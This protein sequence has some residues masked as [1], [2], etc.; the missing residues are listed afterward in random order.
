MGARLSLLAPSAPTVALSSYI[1]VLGDWRYVDVVNNSRF[2]K[3]IR[4]IHVKSGQLVVIKVFIK[5]SLATNYNLQLTQVTELIAKEATLLSGAHNVLPWHKIIETDRAGYLIRQYMKT[6]LYDRLSIR[7]FLEPI[8]KLFI[9]FQL[10][11]AVLYLHDTLHVHH[12]DIKLENIL[13]SSS[14]WVTLSDFSGC[15]KPTFIPEDNPNQFSFYFDTNGRRVCYLAPERFFASSDKTITT[16][17]DEG[18]HSGSDRLTNEMDLFSLGCVIAELYN[19]GEPTFTLS[20]M[21]QYLK[22]AHRPDLS[23]LADPLVRA[24][25][26]G[27]ISRDPNGRKSAL[28]VLEDYR[29]TGFPEYFYDFLYDFMARIN[30]IDEKTYKGDAHVTVSDLKITEIYDMFATIASALGFLYSDDPHE[31]HPSNQMVPLCLSIPGVPTNYCIKPAHILDVSDHG[32]LVVLKL[33]FL[34]MRSLKQPESKLK[35][36]EL[37]VALSERVSDEC[38]LDCSV[39]YLCSFLDEFIE[40]VGSAMWQKV[41]E[42]VPKS[43]ADNYSVKVVCKTLVSITTILQ[44]CS[45]IPPIDLHMFP[46]YL[47]P[48][49][50]TLLASSNARP[51]HSLVRITIASCLPILASLSRKFWMMAKNFKSSGKKSQYFSDAH[52]NKL[53]VPKAQLDNDFEA[54]TVLLL[55]DFEA[56]VKVAFVRNIL[57]ICQFFGAQKANDIVLPHLI[58]FLNDPSD[59]LRSAFLGSVLEVGPFL[60]VITF[61]Q[62][63]L[64]LLVQTLGDCE[65]LVVVKVLEIF[66]LFV[67]SRFVNPLA[68]FN[69]LSIYREMLTSSVVLLL[70]PN[71]WIRQLVL[72]LVLAISDNLLHADRYT[73]LYPLIK[74]YLAFDVAELSWDSLY[75]C[76]VKPLTRQVFDLIISWSL[77]ATPKLLFWQQRTFSQLATGSGPRELLAFAKPLARSVYVPKSGREDNMRHSLPL[78]AEDKQWLLKLRAVGLEERDSWKVLAVREYVYHVSRFNY[79]SAKRREYDYGPV[80]ITPHNVFFEVCYKSELVADSNRTESRSA[81]F[82]MDVS[83]E[84]QRRD[85]GSLVL[86]NFKTVQASLETVRANVYGEIEVGDTRVG[87][88]HHLHSTKETLSSHHVFT[89]NRQKVVTANVKHSYTGTNPYVLQYLAGVRIAPAMESFEEFGSSVKAH[90]PGDD[91]G[92]NDRNGNDTRS[93]SGRT[94]GKPDGGF[95]L[96]GRLLSQINPSHGPDAV[97]CLELSPRGDFFVAGSDSGWLRVWDTAKLEKEVSVRSPSLVARV[98]ASVTS[99]R[100]LPGRSVV[101]AAT[102]DGRILLFRIDAVRHKKSVRYNGITQIRCYELD[103]SEDGYATHLECAN[104]GSVLVAA[105]T[106]GNFV[107]LDVI[108]MEC[109]YRLSA[110]LE[111]GAVNA[112]FMDPHATWLVCGSSMGILTLWDLRFRVV[113][114][115]WRLDMDFDIDDSSQIGSRFAIKRLL[116]LT[117]YGDGSDVHFAMVAGDREPDFSVWTMPKMECCQIYSSHLAYPQ[118]K[119][120]QLLPMDRQ[121]KDLRMEQLT[122]DV[123]EL[124]TGSEPRSMTVLHYSCLSGHH[125]VTSTPQGCITV[126]DVDTPSESRALGTTAVFKTT[127]VSS[128]MVLVNESRGAGDDPGYHEDIVTAAAITKDGLLITADRMGRINAFR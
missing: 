99:L 107:V 7:P 43:N 85:S 48:K 21:F 102:A 118:L 30:Q 73:F 82:A 91:R 19:D 25:V 88:H 122:Q 62:Y 13:V 64:P 22:T 103:S 127:K 54:L 115:T 117:G 65:Q 18:E 114:R 38:K 69:A 95:L 5:P 101:A 116:L 31:Y 109:Q 35:A 41:E 108:K 39:P 79:T 57:P 28:S 119:S 3:T 120:Y 111:H 9:A 75:P 76:L 94:K 17:N 42:S 74:E 44:S 6:N 98:D 59:D 77:A 106:G 52:M 93:T 56:S 68:D 84:R 45:A 105:T 37:V 10:L 55:T 126:W 53:V 14:N 89:V 97:R 125:M 1:D 60:G 80:N 50:T 63:L 121:K 26:S 71:Q 36:C 15:I 67:R 128:S 92:R 113:V 4:A 123:T 20:Q 87:H 124:S 90:E 112:F 110:R 23:T 49:L 46:E 72:N 104:G 16:V 11:K 61:H 81:P 83:H 24:I 66:A 96:S 51:D 27:L 2:L 47:L 8:E 100:F 32:A 12:G 58:T 70:H 78:S 29:G 34:L 33:V 86:P 40:R